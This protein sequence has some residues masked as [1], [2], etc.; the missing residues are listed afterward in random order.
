MTTTEKENL[1][2]VRE[3]T[4]HARWIWTD[5]DPGDAHV[6]IYARRSF[7]VADIKQGWIEITADLRYFLWIN[8]KP[9]GF[10][11]PKFHWETPT[12]DRYEIG[13]WLHT[14][15]NTVT[16]QVYS[17]GSGRGLSSCMPRRGALRAVIGVDDREIFTDKRWKVCREGAYA[18]KTAQRGEA[19]P[20]AECFDARKSLG[21]PWMPRYD[22][23]AWKP[24]TELP[25]LE[26]VPRFELRDIPLF[27][28]REYEADRCLKNG[29][30]HF[31]SSLVE[32]SV[33]HLAED[34]WKAERYPDR[35]QRI[36]FRRGMGGDADICV[37]DAAGLP[38]TD[39]VYTMWDCGRI[40][41]GYPRLKLR[42]SPGA[43]VDLS[44]GECLQ[45]GRINPTKHGLYY[46]DR[47]ILGNEPLEHRITWPKCCRYIQV[48]VRGGRIELEPPVLGRSSYPVERKGSFAC[49]DPALEQAWE[50]SAHTVQLCMEDG[51]MDT[52]WRERGSWLG[53]DVPKM[54]A[55]YAVFGD[56]AL[57]RRF[58]LQHTRGQLPSGQMTGKYPGWKTS[59]VSTW[60]LTF[61]VSVE[62]YIRHSGDRAFAGEMLPTIK[63]ILGWMEQYRLPEGVYGNL[64]LEVTAE[65]NIYNFIDWAPVDTTGA[66]AAWNAHAC[67]CLRA[68]AA[69]A[70]IAGNDT[71][72]NLWL[73]DAGKLRDAFNRLFWNEERG[74]YMNGRH[75]GLL[76]KR[77]G[78][79]ENYLAVIFGLAD[80]QRRERIISNLK[81]EDLLSVFKANK[82]DFDEI[83]PG[84][85]GNHMV[86][87][88]LN[89]YRWDE[90]KMVPPGT[91]YFAW[92]ALEALLKLGM[93]D[94]ALGI[95]SRHWGEYS[96]Q[97]GTTIWETW[98][99]DQ[100][101]LSHGWGCAPAIVLQKYI[102]GVRL[103]D[104][105]GIDVE[106]MPQRDSLR[107][108]SGRVHTRYGT[109]QVSWRYD[110][111]WTLSVDLPEGCR[112]KICLSNGLTGDH[113]SSRNVIVNGGRHLFK[114]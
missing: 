39:G 36:A 65:T 98:D 48:D 104:E 103:S 7:E 55:N 102:L 17:Y 87:I 5:D 96:S 108:A 97:G 95:I 68:A 60:T 38:D 43:V 79:Q 3:F 93:A 59:Y 72:A 61:P 85:D 113:D 52:P 13:Q 54:L 26:P 94:D 105:D 9:A 112:A 24:A 99:R 34:I 56:Y 101:S 86:A 18:S 33:Q 27:N 49:S 41:T 11:P 37:M 110:K 80:D 74:V 22:D 73:A 100:G 92:F 10:G 12:V 42:G 82:E 25:E 81:K 6:W 69:V 8:G 50:I 14:G 16:V 64:P 114:E 75:D 46:A 44:Y 83:I 111:S 31:G 67:N 40:W 78:C 28:W 45:E 47:I 89:R 21:M 84:A 88:A 58:L 107:W 53:D 51:Y 29:I 23:A 20:P 1:F 2:P 70:N 71:L 15:T 76:L 77:W 91:P 30:A 66:N 106:I 90:T 62:E 109:I 19:Q 32:T 57:A 4:E 63:Q 35:E